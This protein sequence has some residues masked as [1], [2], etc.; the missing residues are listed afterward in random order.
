[1]AISFFLFGIDAFAKKFSAGGVEDDAFDLGAAEVDADAMHDLQQI[2]VGRASPR[3][4]MMG[5]WSVAVRLAGTMQFK[6]TDGHR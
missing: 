4:E 1:M 3:A 5:R 2:M 6:T